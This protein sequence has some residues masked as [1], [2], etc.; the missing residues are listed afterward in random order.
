MIEQT[1]QFLR[2]EVYNYLNL[3]TQTHTAE[4]K[5]KLTGLVDAKGDLSLA[6]GCLGLTL[7]NIEEERLLKNQA[8]TFKKQ[9]D[10]VAYVNPDIK[11]NL[12]VLFS[13]NFSPYEE[14]LK[15][16]SHVVT[17]FQ[18]RNA[19][20][21]Q[22]A[23]NLDAGIKKLLVDL[24]S[25]NFEQQNHMWSTLGCKYLPSALYHVRMLCLKDE[26]VLWER[27]PV[28]IVAINADSGGL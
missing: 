3:M 6:S 17:F 16:I 15:F 14:G 7:V 5:V 12:Y 13:A 27:P 10:K 2:L 26:Q 23:P 8:P 9:E 11:L 28:Q 24:Y 19:F 25:M 1:L 21:H 4:N 20:N 18:M 22:N